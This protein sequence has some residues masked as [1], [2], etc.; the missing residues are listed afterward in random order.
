M[1]FKHQKGPAL[2]IVGALFSCDNEAIKQKQTQ[3]QTQNLNQKHHITGGKKNEEIYQEDIIQE[4]FQ[5]R[6]TYLRN[7]DHLHPRRSNPF[8]LHRYL[9]TVRR[10]SRRHLIPNYRSI[11]NSPGH[12]IPGFIFVVWEI[13]K[14]FSGLATP[15]P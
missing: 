6:R 7:R 8:Q 13:S 12:Q 5:P 15:R 3:T 14:L 2:V 9:Q 11:N 10:S 4:G 1:L